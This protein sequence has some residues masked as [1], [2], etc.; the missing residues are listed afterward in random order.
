MFWLNL[1]FEVFLQKAGA[2]TVGACPILGMPHKVLAGYIF[3]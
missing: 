3:S 2:D 1:Y